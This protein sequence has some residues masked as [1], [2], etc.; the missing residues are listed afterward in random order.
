M[1]ALVSAMTTFLYLDNPGMD[2]KKKSDHVTLALAIQVRAAYRRDF[3]RKQLV[4]QESKDDIATDSP[5]HGFS[6]KFFA[7]ETRESTGWHIVPEITATSIQISWKTHLV[8]NEVS[9]QM[10]SCTRT[11]DAAI[12]DLNAGTRTLLM[13]VMDPMTG[14]K[15][16]KFLNKI[17]DQRRTGWRSLGTFMVTS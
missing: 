5:L 6:D 7:D 14:G 11:S 9:P 12:P 16:L 3:P 17:Q 2:M 15:T 8:G 13:D 4:A 1:R 10:Q